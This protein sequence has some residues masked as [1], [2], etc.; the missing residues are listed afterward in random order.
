MT[1]TVEGYLLKVSFG[2]AFIMKFLI[3]YM[4]HSRFHVFIV[5]GLQSNDKPKIQVNES[6]L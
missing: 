3:K 4:F 5:S 1:R 2:S 6:D